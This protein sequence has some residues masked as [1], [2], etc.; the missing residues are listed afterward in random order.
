MRQRVIPTVSQQQRLVLDQDCAIGII[1]R[2]GTCRALELVIH[3][4]MIYPALILRRSRYSKLIVF[5][6]AF[7]G[8]DTKEARA[9]FLESTVIRFDEGEPGADICILLNFDDQWLEQWVSPDSLKLFLANENDVPPMH[10]ARASDLEDSA[11]AFC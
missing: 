11:F 4:G 10:P 9:R 2:P 6:Q 8:L 1:P 5:D 3:H 7:S